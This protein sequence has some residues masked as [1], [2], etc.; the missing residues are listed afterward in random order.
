MFSNVSLFTAKLSFALTN[1]KDVAI[2]EIK[3]HIMRRVDHLKM[4]G[5]LILALDDLI[6]RYYLDVSGDDV[7]SRLPLEPLSGPF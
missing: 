5:R 6:V 7:P 3:R 2:T 1:E 4:E